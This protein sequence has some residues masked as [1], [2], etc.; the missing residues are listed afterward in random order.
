MMPATP[1]AR[2]RFLGEIMRPAATSEAWRRVPPPSD[3]ALAGLERIE[4]PDFATEA[5][6]IA[7]RMREALD[8]PGRTV[9]LVTGDRTLGRRVAIE[10]GRFGVDIDDTAGTPLDQSP[11]GSFL[12]LAARAVI[13]GLQPVPQIGRAHV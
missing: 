4:A 8:A 1:A 7:L 9:A 11:P 12:L 3:A 10:L 6:T 2:R 5:L 13:D